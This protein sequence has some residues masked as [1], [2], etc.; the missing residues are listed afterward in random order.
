MFVYLA[1]LIDAFG[2]QCS[3]ETAR[4]VDQHKKGVNTPR[5]Y[6][7][8][9]RSVLAPLGNVRCVDVTPDAID[10]TFGAYRATAGNGRYVQARAAWAQ[11][12][13]WAIEQ[14]NL[15]LPP[16]RVLA[17]RGLR[18]GSSL[19][20]RRAALDSPVRPDP[21]TLLDA[22]KMIQGANGGIPL[23]ELVGL[24]WEHCTMISE[25]DGRLGSVRIQMHVGDERV[26]VGRDFVDTFAARWQRAN[27]PSAGPVFPRAPGNQD[28]IPLS[29]MEEGLRIVEEELARPAR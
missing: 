15:H 10:A 17:E 9:V 8:A 2:V 3:A 6:A 23:R 19:R 29:Q 4:R 28:P 14:H 20:E 13:R 27:R 1:D 21:Y 12:R 5:V 26:F 25:Q 22:A 11:F 16:G 18:R 7:S 24:R